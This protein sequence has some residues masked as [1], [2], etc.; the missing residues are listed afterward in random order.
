[1]SSSEKEIE[2]KLGEQKEEAKNTE[3]PKITGSPVVGVRMSVSNGTWSNSP[4]VYSYQWE[5]CNTAGKECTPIAGA[6]NANYTPGAGDLNRT[7]LARVTATNGEGASVAS[8]AATTAVLSSSSSSYTQSVDS[9]YSLN[10][11]SCV[12]ST[13]DCVVSDSQGKALYSTNVSASASAATMSR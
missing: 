5:D 10:A 7:L 8:S 11:V 2:E 3:A 9:G 1:M 13:T 4:V 6:T 12:P